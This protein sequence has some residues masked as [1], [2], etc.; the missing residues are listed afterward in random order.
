VVGVPDEKKGEQ[1]VALHALDDAA[2]TEVLKQLPH[3]GLPNL[4][5]PK[6]NQFYRVEQFPLTGTGKLDLRKVREIAQARAGREAT[7]VGLGG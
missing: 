6:P 1:L 3:C 5:I 7:N 2:L 4:W